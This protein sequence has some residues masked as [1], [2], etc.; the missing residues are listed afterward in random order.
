MQLPINKPAKHVATNE[1]AGQMDF[2]QDYA[3]HQNPHVNY[4]PS[5]IGGL[6]EAV[7]PGKEYEPYVEGKLQRNKISRENN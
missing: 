4:E 5:L 6:K 3:E 7:N 2:R 1:S